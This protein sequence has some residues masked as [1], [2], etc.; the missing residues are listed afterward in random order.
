MLILKKFN[1]VLRECNLLKE[2]LINYFRYI[3]L[4]KNLLKHFTKNLEYVKFKY[5]LKAYNLLRISVSLL[6]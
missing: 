4:P 2:I 5:F 3:L 1:P 6:I